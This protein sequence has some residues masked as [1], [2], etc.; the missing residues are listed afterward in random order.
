MYTSLDEVTA[1]AQ[2]VIKDSDDKMRNLYKSWVWE[3]TLNLGISDD[4]IKVAELYPNNFTAKL[5]PDCRYI[6]EVSCFDK[7]GTQLP[8][9][10]R[11]GNRRIYADTRMIVT[12]TTNGDP[13]SFIPV[14]ISNDRYNIHLGTNGQ[15]VGTI[16]IRYFS[17]PL[18]ENG[19]PLIRE[20]DKMACVFFVRYMDALR[21]DD[22]RSKI[23]QDEIAWFREADRARARKKMTS[24]TPDKARTMMR[25]LQSLV[26]NFRFI[27]NF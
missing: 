26:P 19:Q 8:H 4:E 16:I 2:T 15:N 5:P 9:Q 20:E 11:G 1:L 21:R 23:Q 14:D 6:I 24:V 12:G 13:N 10:Y 7:S 17:Y 18:D 25:S 27:Q 3:A 22:N